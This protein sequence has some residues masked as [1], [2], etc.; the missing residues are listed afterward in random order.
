MWEFLEKL[1]QTDRGYSSGR[2]GFL[3]TVFLSNIIIWPLFL[4][5]CIYNKAFVN[6][7][8]GVVYL[9]GAAQGIS[10]AGKA[11]QSFADRNKGGECD[12]PVGKIKKPA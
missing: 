9:Y 3:V 1:F 6:I 8:E 12:K 11:A 2:I 4:G 7:P 10:F 5:L